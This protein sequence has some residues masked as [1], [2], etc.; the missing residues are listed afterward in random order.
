MFSHPQIKE[1]F[2]SVHQKKL[3]ESFQSFR[4]QSSKV[5]EPNRTNTPVLVKILFTVTETQFTL[6]FFFFKWKDSIN[7]LNPQGY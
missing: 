7:P 4:I 1:M 2:G 5:K 6:A 3:L